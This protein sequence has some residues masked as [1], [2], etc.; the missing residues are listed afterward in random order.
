MPAAGQKDAT[1]EDVQVLG[2]W[3]FTLQP[4]TPLFWLKAGRL[5]RYLLRYTCRASSQPATLGVVFH[6]EADG[7]GTDGCSF[8]IERQPRAR[9]GD[10][11][12]TYCLSGDALESRPIVT[13]SFPDVP[14]QYEEE[15][16][17]Y[18]QGYT[19][20]IFLNGKKVQLKFRCKRMSGSVAFYN[21]SKDCDVSFAR[22]S[23]TALHRGP[24]EVAGILGQREQKLLASKSAT[25]A[26]ERIG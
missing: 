11:L 25:G 22:V 24:M 15:V 1:L 16:Q 7:R 3:N 21:T 8:W 20:C 13:R 4:D 10:C 17:I 6:A 19:G 14:G 2:E 5:D 12:K 9:N 18:I 23:I 26:E